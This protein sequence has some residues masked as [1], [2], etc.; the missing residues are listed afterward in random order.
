[1]SASIL[2]FGR[3]S[4]RPVLRRNWSVQEL[5]E[6]YRVAQRLGE[7]GIRVTV[8]NGLSDEGD[9]WAVFEQIDTGD[10]VV[11][12]ARIDEV[13]TIV[14]SACGQIYRG[15]DFR[16]VT[17]Q[18]LQD[19]PAAMPRVPRASNV[20]VHP[21]AVLTAFVAAAVV[22]TELVRSTPATAGVAEPAP[23]PDGIFTA[24]LGRVLSRDGSIGLIGSGLSGGAVA[25]AAASLAT[26]FAFDDGASSAAAFHDSDT[27]ASYL[28]AVSEMPIPP[29]A[30]IDLSQAVYGLEQ[31][32]APT[33]PAAVNRAM[34]EMVAGPAVLS[35]LHIQIEQHAAQEHE[36]DPQ[37]TVESR[38]EAMALA[39]QA[40]GQEREKGGAEAPA[41]SGKGLPTAVAASH[42][43][44]EAS[45]PN[46]SQFDARF[47]D[48]EKKAI[49]DSLVIG[50]AGLDLG[51][52]IVEAVN[53][54]ESDG[55][56]GKGAFGGQ[57]SAARAPQ[58]SDPVLQSIPAPAGNNHT[59]SAAKADYTAHF[60][61][62]GETL[63]TF[64]S[65][66]VDVLVVGKGTTYVENFR[67]GEDILFI[68]GMQS[69]SSSW[70][71]SV[72]FV[73]D[74][75]RIIGVDGSQIWLLDAFYSFV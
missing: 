66:K 68:D 31:A 19:A 23:S 26:G 34:A 62:S 53:L 8:D 55:A 3:R 63:L 45:L 75:V 60:A 35:E 64:T 42:V 22:L 46:L 49:V 17:E 4:V 18:M 71:R 57:A 30:P 11:H 21:R 5:A 2:S 43:S 70:F 39:V 20:V 41:E 9:P 48:S 37:P 56:S 65:G 1:M 67:F 16:A 7:S 40:H 47:T 38:Q 58:S 44:H 50:E 51:K 32:V 52:A 6:L 29:S 33:L 36:L 59:S 13:L 72:S 25:W 12:I 74:D 15:S 73:G 28:A 27:A 10:V 24:L 54:K 69:H 61:A 14:N